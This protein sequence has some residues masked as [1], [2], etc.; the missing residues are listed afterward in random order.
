MSTNLHKS[1]AAVASTV[2]C[3]FVFAQ[4]PDDAKLQQLYERRDW[5]GL[6]EAV[7]GRNASPLYLGAAASAFNQV[8]EAKK[9]L[10]QVIAKAPDSKEARE[11][12]ELLTYLYLR[13]GRS[14]DAGKHI[15]E[16][17]KAEPGRADLRN[18]QTIFSAF[19]SGSNLEIRSRND[20]TVECEVKKDGVHVPLSVNGHSVTWLIDTG[21][22][23]SV[24]S[25]A[26]ERG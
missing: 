12:R 24:L 5:F 19:A 13:I 9:R 8:D 6:R 4:A 18:V 11:A 20:A 15:E 22:N 14:A 23:I 16:Q 10:G 1:I 7:D 2:L 26:E 21:A 17:L 25:D 3:A